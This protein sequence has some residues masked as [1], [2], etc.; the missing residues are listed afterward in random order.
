M[1]LKDKIYANFK[2]GKL[3]FR[4]QKE[5]CIF[6]SIRRGEQRIIEKS[7]K[8]LCDEGALCHDEHYRYATP[9]QMGALTGT[10][11]ASKG[12]YAFLIP[13]DREK[14]PSD[15][16]IPGRGLNGALHGDKVLAIPHRSAK[17]DDE[18]RVISVLERG[19]SEIVGTLYRDRYGC[20]LR[21]DE[22][23]YAEDIFIP[24]KKTLNAPMGVKAVAKITSYPN[25][26]APGG[27]IIEIL[28]EG[29]DFFVEELSIIRAHAL[30]EEFPLEVKNAAAAMPVSVDEKLGHGR[31]DLRDKLIIT[32]D[33]EDTRDID[34]AISVERDGDDYLL[35]V[36]IADV[37]EYVKYKGALD[38]EAFRRGTSVYFP[39]RVL[40]ML[41]KELSNGICSLNEGVDRL[42][43]SCF[44]RIG[45]NGQVKEGKVCKSII[46]STH[47]TTYH[48]IE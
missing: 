37:T 12:G 30:R 16:F 38:K 7:L 47:R 29:D 24:Q 35:G 39:D 4:T 44:M 41:P 2:N 21:P 25:G 10:V 26:K 36:H 32:V 13:D 9:T 3:S 27:E 34:D 8:E 18:V 14:Y 33:G 48:E 23:R 45:K 19:Y 15:F 31:L 17:S 1:S 43:L 6:L 20:F 46:R 42:T 28:G 11:S 40:P 22:S 5:I